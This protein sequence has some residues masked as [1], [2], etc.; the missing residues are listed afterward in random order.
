MAIT[1]T[2][3]KIEPSQNSIPIAISSFRFEDLTPFPLTANML[4]T[5]QP[6]YTRVKNPRELRE[7][8]QA[9]IESQQ[10]LLAAQDGR[11]SSGWA[12]SRQ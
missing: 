10:R 11:L 2:V 1:N 4:N 7:E 12:V 8:A 3:V 9:V 6:K 5:L